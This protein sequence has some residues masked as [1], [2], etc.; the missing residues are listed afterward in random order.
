MK[1]IMKA[2][3][4]TKTIGC[5]SKTT[6]ALGTLAATVTEAELDAFIAP[7]FT[8]GDAPCKGVDHLYAPHVNVNDNDKDWRKRKDGSS[9]TNATI[10]PVIDPDKFDDRTA[11]LRDLLEGYG[12]MKHIAREISILVGISITGSMGRIQ[13]QIK[14]GQIVQAFPDVTSAD[15]PKG[16]TLWCAASSIEDVEAL[17]LTVPNLVKALL[18]IKEAE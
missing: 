9:Y 3:K 17:H 11:D 4:K 2:T 12:S 15:E 18:K 7:A 10:R 1:E 14:R 8:I 5:K 13:T 16:P 6:S